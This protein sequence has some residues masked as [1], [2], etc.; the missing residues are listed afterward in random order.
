[1]RYRLAVFGMGEGRKTDVKGLRQGLS[2]SGSLGDGYDLL[3][4]KTDGSGMHK[5]KQLRN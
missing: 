4:T 1:M 2:Y 3:E 5:P